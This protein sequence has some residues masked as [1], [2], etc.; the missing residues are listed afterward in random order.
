MIVKAVFGEG[1]GLHCRMLEA[2]DIHIEDAKD[3]GYNEVLCH[4]VGGGD[5]TILHLGKNST[6]HLYIMD[7]GKTVDHFRFDQQLIT[8]N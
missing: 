4:K 3:G 1:G 5:P 2:I 8:S 7:K 6:D